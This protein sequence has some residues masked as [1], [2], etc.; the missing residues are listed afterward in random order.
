MIL[1]FFALRSLEETYGKNL[2]FIEPI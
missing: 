1:A 2:D